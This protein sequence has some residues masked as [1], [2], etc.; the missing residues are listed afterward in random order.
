M[1][2][3][4]TLPR[5]VRRL[6]PVALLGLT[7]LG[8]WSCDSANP[9][10]PPGTLLIITA[11]PSRIGLNGV[12]A[13]IVT[14]RRP[15]GNP[16]PDGTEIRLSTSLGVIES[17][18]ETVDGGVAQATLRADGRPGTA[19]VTATVGGE[20][21]ATIDVVIGEPPETQPQVTV[22]VNPNNIP[23]GDQSTATVT[24]VVRNPDGTP[25]PAGLSVILTTTLGRLEPEQTQT[26]AN[27]TAT[28][29]LFAG[30]QSGNAEVAAFVGSADRATTSVTIR[31]AAA[32]ISLQPNP[33]S[34]PRTDFDIQ[35]VA[36]VSNT[37]GLPFQGQSVT[38]LTEVGS[39][40]NNVAFTDT[41]GQAQV[42]L[43]V[44]QAQLGMRAFFTVRART[45]TGN[46]QFIEAE[47][48][49]NIQ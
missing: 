21:E 34:I 42:T 32:A 33:T 47:A 28:S 45:P 44:T 15:D 11:N 20:S 23:V 12:A 24:V 43:S 18:V 38:F 35:L 41:N 3:L 17:I 25:G 7:L 13:I 46:G 36:F 6:V 8:S 48:V 31:D 37:Q 2:S 40:A 27:G 26:D 16:L 19:T 22:T 10:A 39:F 30:L 14:G 9:L 49:I 1:K 4:K 29:T 5:L